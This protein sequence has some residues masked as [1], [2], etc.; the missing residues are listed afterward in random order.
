[1]VG[2]RPPVLVR[3]LTKE[4]RGRLEAG[5]HAKDLYEVRRCRIL[6]ASGRG[7]WAPRIAELLGC[8]D[9]TVPNVVREFGDAGLKACLTRGSSRPHTLHR[10]VG[11]G[12]EEQIR[13]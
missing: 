8:T 10:K 1:M 11:E 4:E 3:K 5:L 6:L 2:M 9:Q 7:M 13:A 12:A